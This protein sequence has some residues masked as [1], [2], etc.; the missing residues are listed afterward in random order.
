MMYLVLCILTN[1]SKV[2]V[3]ELEQILLMHQI[4]IIF[5]V[6]TLLENNVL[7]ELHLIW[8]D[9]QVWPHQLS[10]ANTFCLMDLVRR[11]IHLPIQIL[12]SLQRLT[13]YTEL[14]TTLKTQSTYYQKIL[15]H[16]ALWATNWNR[17]KS[18][19]ASHQL[20]SRW[21]DLDLL[22]RIA[23]TPRWHLVIANTY[24]RIL[25]VNKLTI[26]RRFSTKLL[27]IA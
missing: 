2:Q 18:T 6:L 21:N 11:A 14:I 26:S 1:S 8:Q 20:L 24:Q 10:Q 15:I 3:S 25:L 27:L 16:S 7:K 9:L 19:S 17:S 4:H 13:N 5:K 12:I 22:T 23:T